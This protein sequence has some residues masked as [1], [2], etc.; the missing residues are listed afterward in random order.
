MKIHPR[1]AMKRLLL[2]GVVSAA[3]L[4]AVPAWAQVEKASIK[5]SMGWLFQATQAQFPLSAEKGYWKAEGLE[6]TV[7]RGSGSATSIQRVVSG[8]YDLAYADMGTVIKWNL[9]NPGREVLAVYVAEDG[10]PLAAVA[11]KKSGIAKPKDLEAKRMGAP[12]FDGGRQMFPVFAKA[13]SIDT[14]KI[15]WTSMDANLREQMLARGDIDA[16]T[17]FI[18]SAVPSLNA[19]GVKTADLTVMRYDAYGLDGYGNAVIATREFAEKNPKT[20]TA[21]VKGLNRGMKEMIA[22]PKDAI[23]A[24][25][26]RDPLINVANESDRMTLYIKELLLTKNVRENG[27]SAVYPPKLLREIDSVALA[28]GTKSSVT[29]ANVYTDRFLPP[30]A[31]RMPPSWKE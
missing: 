11:L 9:E 10:F 22:N 18:T 17:G 16:I 28:F 20:V 27:F 21:F 26:A 15:V 23:A 8:S 25:R 7:D 6:V 24:L 14:S 30:K 13:N 19:L 29:P 2:A 31:D 4:L 5:F 1:R 3:G 12:A